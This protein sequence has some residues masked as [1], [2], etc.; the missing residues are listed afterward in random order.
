[1]NNRFILIVV[2]AIVA[3]VIVMNSFYTVDET[4]QVIVLQMGEYKR[5]VTDPG[6]HLKMPFIQ[7]VKSLDKRVLT[8]SVEKEKYITFNQDDKKNEGDSG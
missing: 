1:M 5:T 3:I 6:L 4:E 2:L 8:S 7:S